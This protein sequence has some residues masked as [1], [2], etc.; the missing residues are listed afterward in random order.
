MTRRQAGTCTSPIDD[1]AKHKAVETARHV[2]FYRP[3]AFERLTPK[4]WNAGRARAAVRAIVAD[5]D[6]S[7]R[8][9]KLFWRA[10]DW[11]RW[12][13]TNPM[14]NLDVGTAGVLWALDELRRRGH[15]ATTLDLPDLALRNLGLFR[16]GRTT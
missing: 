1:A 6:A 11:D 10:E 16:G 12:H 9:P 8:G 4:R 15:A 7:F 3:E 14:K 13:T 2:V 5:T